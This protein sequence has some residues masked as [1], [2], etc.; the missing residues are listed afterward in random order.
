MSTRSRIQGLTN[1]S[2]SENSR[3]KSQAKVSELTV[4]KRSNPLTHVYVL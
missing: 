3:N 1:D 4:R 2:E